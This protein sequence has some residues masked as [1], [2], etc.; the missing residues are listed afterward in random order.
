MTLFLSPPPPPLYHSHYVSHNEN[1]PFPSLSLSLSLFLSGP[2]I[3]IEIS[4]KYELNRSLLN[5]TRFLRTTPEPQT[6][7]Q[8]AQSLGLDLKLDDEL[9]KKVSSNTKI[10]FDPENV[11]FTYKPEHDVKSKQDLLDLL[12][13]RRLEGGGM[14]VEDF[15]DSYLNIKEA[16]A[17]LEKDGKILIVRKKDGYPRMLFYNDTVY[18]T[19]MATEFK[20]LWNR[21]KMPMEAEMV[22][23]LEAAG[24]KTLRVRDSGPRRH[25]TQMKRGITRTRKVKLTNTHLAG[26]VDLSKDY[27]PPGK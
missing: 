25:E 23:E 15:K 2:L 1:S 18:N 19:P 12:Q 17:E 4:R 27:A 24:H 20:E 10:I 26:I 14:L 8:I 3:S 13:R 9:F 22:A 16:M 6:I 5:I 11:T 21:Y 7:D